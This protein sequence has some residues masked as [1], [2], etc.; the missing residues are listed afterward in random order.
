MNNQPTG[1]RHA[2]FTA[3][4]LLTTAAVLCILLTLGIPVFKAAI[5]NNRMSAARNSITTH[6]N[7]ARSEAVKRGIGMVLCPSISGSSCRSS[8]IW[9]NGFM[10]FVDSNGSRQYE[11]GEQI[12]RYIDPG[13]ANIR[14]S[15]STGRR[16]V[17]YNQYGFASGYNLTFTFCEVNNLVEPRAVIVS[18]SG[19]ARLSATAANG[20]PLNCS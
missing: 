4:E 8:T 7:L 16:K 19:R 14:I 1:R 5:Q 13:S 17:V 20:D 6:L 10:L 12:L 15:S 3:I 11:P 18:S 9:S 2:G